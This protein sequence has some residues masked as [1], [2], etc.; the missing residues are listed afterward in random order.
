MSFTKSMISSNTD[1]WATPPSLSDEL[2]SK[3]NFEVDVCAT[4]ENAKCSKY[5]TKEQD[6]LQQQWEGK[7]WCKY[8]SDVRRKILTDVAIWCNSSFISVLLRVLRENT[9]KKFQKTII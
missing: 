3:Y 8:T 9:F 5:Y 4:A 7:C 1:L 2:D 6:G